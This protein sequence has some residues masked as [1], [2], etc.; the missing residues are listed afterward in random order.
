MFASYM[1]M[2]AMYKRVTPEQW[3]IQD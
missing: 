2:M 1:M 3:R